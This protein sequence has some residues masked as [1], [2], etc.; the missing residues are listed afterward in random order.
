MFKLKSLCGDNIP[1]QDCQKDSLDIF[2][3]INYLV[4]LHIL[5]K[6]EDLKHIVYVFQGYMLQ[7]MHR[8]CTSKSQNIQKIKMIA[9]QV[10]I[11]QYWDV[12][13]Q[14]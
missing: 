4:L 12:Y 5:K 10:L 2:C 14:S 13:F 7:D 8:S 1:K 3:D 9:K 6:K 11:I